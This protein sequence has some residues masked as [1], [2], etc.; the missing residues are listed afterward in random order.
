[1]KELAVDDSGDE[2]FKKR[3]VLGGPLEPVDEAPQPVSIHSPNN[4]DLAL[5]SS[6]CVS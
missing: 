6:L 5:I 3:P 2:P 4:S 1:V